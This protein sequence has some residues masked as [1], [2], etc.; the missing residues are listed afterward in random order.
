[1]A[2]WCMCIVSVARQ[3]TNADSLRLLPKTYFTLL[4]LKLHYRTFV[5][6]ILCDKS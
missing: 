4:T 2:G 3:G 1:M 5:F 6:K